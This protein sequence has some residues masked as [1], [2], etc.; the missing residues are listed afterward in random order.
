MKKTIDLY[1]FVKAFEEMG[2]KEHFSEKGLKALFDD[3]VQYEE[4]T[5]DEIELD[6]IAICCEFTEYSNFEEFKENYSDYVERHNIENLEDLE[7]HTY[8]IRVDDGF[9]IQD[10]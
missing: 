7:N 10:F 2:R 1:D 9:I 5:G 3:F 6:V 4:D 8:V